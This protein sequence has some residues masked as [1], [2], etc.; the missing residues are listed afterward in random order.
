M[1]RVAGTIDLSL[2][3]AKEIFGVPLPFPTSGVQFAYILA[4][5]YIVYEVSLG[6]GWVLNKISQCLKKRRRKSLLRKRQ[7]RSTKALPQL[8]AKPQLDASLQPNA[9]SQ[10]NAESQPEASLQPQMPQP[11]AK[12]QQDMSK[13]S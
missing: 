5:C 7:K 13:A 9:S 1:F 10:P 4:V 3:I 6:I 11:V 12:P 8:T 2:I